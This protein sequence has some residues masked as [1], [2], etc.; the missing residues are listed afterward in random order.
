MISQQRVNAQPFEEIKALL[1]IGDLSRYV[2]NI[3]V[4]KTTTSSNYSLFMKLNGRYEESEREYNSISNFIIN[5]LQDFKVLKLVYVDDNAEHDRRIQEWIKQQK[6]YGSL[7][8]YSYTFIGGD[9]LPLNN[10]TGIGIDIMNDILSK[11]RLPTLPQ[12]G[13]SDAYYQKYMKY[14]I[15]YLNLRNK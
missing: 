6:P 14:K 8:G 5:K 15:K 3:L 7:S 4:Q 2:S 11:F 10:S 13:G 1:N 9:K 12:Q